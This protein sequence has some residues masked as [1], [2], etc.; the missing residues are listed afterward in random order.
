MNIDRIKKY[1]FVVKILQKSFLIGT[2]VEKQTF[3]NNFQILE[4]YCVYYYLFIIL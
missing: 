2:Y 4:G 1:V 3:S